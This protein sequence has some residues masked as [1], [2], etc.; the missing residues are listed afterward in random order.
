MTPIKRHVYVDITCNSP[1]YMREVSQ[2]LS[3]WKHNISA[4]HYHCSIWITG[5]QVG[6][7]SNRPGHSDGLWKA[8]VGCNRNVI[9]NCMMHR[10]PANQE[11]LRYEIDRMKHLS[12]FCGKNLNQILHYKRWQSRLLSTKCAKVRTCVHINTLERLTLPQSRDLFQ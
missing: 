6:S 10:E 11:Y 5:V 9:C 4:C 7:Y 3:A 8:I 12:L 1:N 2:F